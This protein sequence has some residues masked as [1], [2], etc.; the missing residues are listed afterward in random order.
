M[1]SIYFLQ[2]LYIT[3]KNREIH[4]IVWKDHIWSTAIIPL[5]IDYQM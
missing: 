5:V 3:D 1:C 4:A 2:C